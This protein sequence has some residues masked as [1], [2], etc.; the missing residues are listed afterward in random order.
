MLFSIFF[1]FSRDFLPRQRNKQREK[2]ITFSSYLGENGLNTFCKTSLD[3][4][5]FL[6]V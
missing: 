6:S 4:I 3:S 5:Q 2:K 1:F